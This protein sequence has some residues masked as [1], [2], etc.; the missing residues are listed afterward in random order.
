MGNPHQRDPQIAE[1]LRTYSFHQPSYR[2]STNVA[3]DDFV[4]ATGRDHDL[5]EIKR[6]SIRVTDDALELEYD[7]ER[8][9]ESDSS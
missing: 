9:T 5:D 3:S 7:L 6:R 2:H 8:Q 1:T 4:S